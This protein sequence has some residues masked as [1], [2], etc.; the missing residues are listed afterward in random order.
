MKQPRTILN[1]ITNFA[2]SLCWC[3][4]YTAHCHV[5]IAWCKTCCDHNI[6]TTKLSYCMWET[7]LEPVHET[8]QE[9]H[10]RVLNLKY[11]SHAR[12]ELV[13]SRMSNNDCGT[14]G[15]IR[16]TLQGKE[17]VTMRQSSPQISRVRLRMI[18]SCC[19]YCWLLLLLLIEWIEKCSFKTLQGSCV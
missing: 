19:G 9:Y 17:L 11:M 16:K 7:G 6:I 14:Y 3:L 8:V 4:C 10:L 2:E 5:F 15:R 12:L 18:T 13:M 1:M